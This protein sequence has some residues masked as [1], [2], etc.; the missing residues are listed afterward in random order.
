MEQCEAHVLELEEKKTDIEAQL[1]TPEGAQDAKL[2][3]QYA[4]IQAELKA[5]EAEWEAAMEALE[6]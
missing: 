3:E 6:G 1:A 5:A 4:E 2:F